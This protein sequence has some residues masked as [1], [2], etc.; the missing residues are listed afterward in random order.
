[1]PASS[2]L[3]WTKYARCVVEDVRDAAE[4]FHLLVPADALDAFER[5]LGEWEGVARD[6]DPFRWAADVE[7]ETVEYL[8]H[9]W[10][11]LAT[12][13]AG[14]AQQRGVSLAPTE[15]EPF[16]QAVVTALLDA[17]G[18]E[19]RAGSQ[20]S[21]HLRAFWPGLDRPGDPPAPR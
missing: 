6:G 14:R 8:V 17:L 20:F 19:G 18:A 9:A 3:A 1:M 7:P 4:D 2:V 10:F 15:G 11:V 21:D 5:Y 16:Y 13:L 12:R